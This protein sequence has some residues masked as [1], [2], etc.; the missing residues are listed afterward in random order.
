[1]SAKCEYC[2]QVMFGA[3]G[4]TKS[5]LPIK[6]KRYGCIRVGTEH[7]PL[8]VYYGGCHDCVSRL[9]EYHHP[10]CDAERYSVC[11]WQRIDCDC[12]EDWAD[13]KR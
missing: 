5:F 3:C 7:D 10:G 12:E 4:S 13:Y 9:G 6:D 8:P 2:G 1:M 11:W